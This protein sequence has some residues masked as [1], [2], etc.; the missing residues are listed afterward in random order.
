MWQ[1]WYRYGIETVF[2]VRGG[3]HGFHPG[4]RDATRLD[5]TLF[6]YP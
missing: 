4:A 2:G 6:L 5:K 1:S 3:F